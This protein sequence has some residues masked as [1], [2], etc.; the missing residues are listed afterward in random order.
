M[1]WRA[2]KAVL[3]LLAIAAATALLRLTATHNPNRPY[4]NVPRS[5]TRATEK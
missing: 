1:R 3:G 5:T 2:S 4:N